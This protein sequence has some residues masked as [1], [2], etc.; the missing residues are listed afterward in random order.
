MSVAPSIAISV[1]APLAPLMRQVLVRLSLVTFCPESPSSP[2]VTAGLK[3]INCSGLRTFK[4]ML[5]TKLGS[6]TTL[7][8]GRSVVSSGGVSETVTDSCT[9]SGFNFERDHLRFAHFQGESR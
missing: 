3:L 4:G 8:S 1:V 5:S 7:R 2:L 6:I 9:D